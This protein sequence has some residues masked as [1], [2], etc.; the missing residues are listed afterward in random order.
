MLGVAL[1]HPAARLAVA[2]DRPALEPGRVQAP[3]DPGAA[4]DERLDLEVLLPDAAVPQV[5]R[6]AGDEEVGGLEDVPVGGDD[7]VASAVMVVTFLRWT[8]DPSSSRNT[9]SRTARS[10]FAG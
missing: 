6:E 8:R 4:L 2:G 7:K 9:S 5:L 1:G 10:A 3:E